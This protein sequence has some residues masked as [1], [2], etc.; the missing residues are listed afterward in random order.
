M[1]QSNYT[2]L[3][4]EPTEGHTL[5]Q[6]ADVSI[7]ERILSK[8]IFLAVNDSPANWKEITDSEAEQIRIEQEAEEN[9]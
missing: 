5:T 1:I 9:K 7:A 6:S 8:K 2:V 4:L 3:I